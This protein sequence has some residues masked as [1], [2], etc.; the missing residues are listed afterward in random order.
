[1]PRAQAD[2]AQRQPLTLS[3]PLFR[4]PDSHQSG[5]EE[6]LS[7]KARLMETASEKQPSTIAL[8]GMGGNGKTAVAEEISSDPKIREAF[9]GGVLWLG[10]GLDA[11]F[12]IARAVSEGLAKAGVSTK[13]LDLSSDQMALQA[14]REGLD[15]QP[16]LVVHDDIWRAQQLPELPV[17]CTRL[18][19]TRVNQ[20]AGEDKAPISVGRLPETAAHRLLAH[21]IR[22][23]DEH[24]AQRLG[25]L[26]SSL[27]G[28]TLLLRLVN[29]E[30]RAAQDNGQPLAKTLDDFEAFVDAQ[31]ISAL[32][33]AHGG[34]EAQEL[35][36]IAV[37]FCLDYGFDA[38]GENERR[39][40]Y[41]L[42]IVPQGTEMPVDAACDF[43][44]H[45]TGVSGLRA[46]TLLKQFSGRSIFRDFDWEAETFR[47]H[48]EFWAFFRTVVEQEGRWVDLHGAMLS[49]LGEHCTGAWS[50]L[51][52]DHKYGWKQLLYHL[53]ESGGRAEIDELR[54]DYCWL[55]AKLRAI[56]AQE[57]HSSFSVQPKSSDVEKVGR[58]IA[59]SLSVISKRKEAFALQI[60][61]RL[62]H[63]ASGSA[64]G[65]CEQARKDVD[66]Y[67]IPSKPHL[68]PLGAERIRLEGHGQTVTSAIFSP[69]GTRA[70][71]ASE[72][73]TA[74]LWDVARG[75]E[76]WSF[77][78]HGDWVQSAVF[79]SDGTKVLTASED[80]TAR[81]WDV[82]MG[83]EIMS[84]D[85]HHNEVSSAV[86]S[87]DD[88][89]IL[90]ASHD[91]TARLWDAETGKQ[92]RLFD[93]HRLAVTSAVF[94]ADSTRVL[95]ASDDGTARLWDGETGRQLRLFLGHGEAVKSA[96]FSPDGTRALT[97]SEDGTARLWDVA[98]GKQIRSFNGHG[99][100]VQSAVFSP[101]GTKV[102]T[103]SLDCT[104]GLWDLGT[105]AEI[106][107][108]EGH[109]R[110]VT[111]AVFSS[112]GARVLTA[113]SDRTARV[114]DI[115]AGMKSSSFERHGDVVRSAVF[116]RVGTEVLTSS[117]DHTAR[118]WDAETGKEILRCEGHSDFLTSAVFSPDGTRV[119][120]ASQDST[121]RLWDA[122]AGTEVQRFEGHAAWV[123]SA[124]LSRD[125]TRVLTA[126]WDHT[127]RLWE[128][129]TG[130]EVSRFEGHGAA[131]SSA[132]FSP[133]DA[134]IVTASHDHTARLWDVE[135]CT[136]IWAF[137]GHGAWL[138]SS[139]FSPDG[140]S[141][142]TASGDG[143]A[144][145]WNV[146]T[147]KQLRLF[148]GHRLAVT[149]AV[150][151][152][153]STRVLTASDDGTARLWSAETGKQ[154]RLFEGHGASVKVAM[155]SRD[156]TKVFTASLDQTVRLWDLETAVTE[157]VVNL[158]HRALVL[159]VSGSRFVVCDEAGCVSFFDT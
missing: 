17:Q 156:T 120:T 37:R 1:M 124:V 121:A 146:E 11:S 8:V 78:G 7:A 38:L 63:E 125:S 154:L 5:R 159:D 94:S 86:F 117:W 109:G 16:V 140:T 36:R 158:D 73:G 60:Y 100:W 56:G 97:T 21:K 19:T 82:K 102:L 114:W 74:R 104:A 55:R 81:L 32:D 53:R 131:V 61:G 87:P 132:V 67:P 80:G 13:D 92:L 85:G 99:D 43:A 69:D 93:G 59:L 72:D 105:G 30:L 66:F 39:V 149:S 96:V 15:G 28:W 48:D 47:M 24:S 108:F 150:F 103:A 83:T 14:L 68:L 40:F 106:W 91:H 95:T 34:H 126:A 127:A 42:G 136:Q 155:L 58:A 144:R 9:P 148:E 23:E 101:D 90:T 31:D 46:K 107:R 52:Q 130:T 50:T 29:D 116:S 71:T 25:Q 151:S 64:I 65:I 89:S 62:G 75:K 112:D 88:A 129:E 49:A 27:R 6:V 142:L 119:L 4:L 134:R 138:T 135:T 20:I 139:V 41:N 111:S 22:F 157:A 77:N 44:R 115:D 57:L 113:S 54:T 153:D 10:F 79:S 110:P 84:F 26:A 118:L 76:I 147:G 35:R 45:A 18:I 2:T 137:E 122:E 152:A 70:L 128:T 33:Q 145:L 12:T 141:V 3:A 51:K 123:V 143:T 133:D 98:R